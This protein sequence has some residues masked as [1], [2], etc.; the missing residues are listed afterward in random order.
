V[1]FDGD[2]GFILPEFKQL[3]RHDAFTILS[4]I[5]RAALLVK[6][7]QSILNGST[8]LLIRWATL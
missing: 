7:R 1:K 3:G 4:F 8:P 2:A 6:V 5:S